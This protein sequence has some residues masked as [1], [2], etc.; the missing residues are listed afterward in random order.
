MAN[1]LRLHQ[2]LK[3]LLLLVPAVAAHR[4]DWQTMMNLAAA[5]ASFS[6]CA[7]GGYVL[8][9]VL[10]IAADRQHARKRHRPFA[11]GDLS[12]RSGAILTAIVWL[13]GFGLSSLL[14]PAPFTAA[15]AAYL[16]ATSAYSIRLKREPVVDVMVLAGVYVLRV[17]AG[18]IAA[19]VLVSSWLLAFT[20]FISLS[21]AYVKRYIE[22][23]ANSGDTDAAVPGR[24]YRADDGAWLHG[25]GISSGYLSAVVLAIY[26]NN[27]DVTLLYTHP[28]RLL[29]IC[30]LLLYWQTRLWLAAHRRQIHDDPVV[31]V[32]KDPVTYFLG[33]AALG[34]VITAV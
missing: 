18:G 15:V 20:L 3:N 7:S 17:V 32:A 4:L 6:L 33:A 25:V 12:L 19:G 14:L 1:A 5:F 23:S 9:D 28:E 13:V 24:G 22:V 8:N 34:I 30:P 26:V 27:A 21:L 10:D 2:W 31:A 16:A 29:L 11:A